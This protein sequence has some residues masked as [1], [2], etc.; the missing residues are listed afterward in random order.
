MGLASAVACGGSSDGAS[1]GPT[2][3]GS[4]GSSGTSGGE[5]SS[6][7][8][9]SSGESSS[10]S[11]GSSGDAS[12]DA[13]SDGA[14]VTTTTSSLLAAGG[15]LAC[16]I[17]PAG[18]L[19]CWGAS[20]TP[21]AVAAGSTFKDIS[22]GSYTYTYDFRGCAIRSDDTLWCFES[23][24]MSL[25]Q[26]DTGSFTQ[27][28]V[29][30]QNQCAIAK[31]GA[32]YCWGTN[33]TYGQL[34]VGDN[35][36]THTTLVQVGTD[37][38]WKRV[39]TSQDHTCALDATGALYCW[40]LD[41][42]GQ[43]G[44]GNPDATV[45]NYASSPIAIAAGTTWSDVSVHSSVTCGVR[46][47]GALLCWGQGAYLGVNSRTPATVDTAKDWAKVRLSPNHACAIKKTGTLY[48]WGF[49]SF[50]QIGQPADPNG[51]RTTPQQV[52]SDADWIDVAVGAGFSCATKSDATIRCWGTNDIGQLGQAVAGHT[53]PQRVGAA[54]E[55]SYVGAGGNG[56]CAVK[57]NGTL[58]CW[59]SGGGLSTPSQVPVQIGAGTTW[60]TAK[61]GGYR[62]CATQ[63]DGSLYCWTP[64]VGA[65]AP[66]PT[67]LTGV[68]SYS[69]GSDHQCA[70][71]AGSLYCWGDGIFGKL[72]NGSNDDE[73]SPTKVGAATWSHVAA[74]ADDT[75][76]V[77]SDGTTWCWGLGYSSPQ[78]ITTATTWTALAQN[79][80]GEN[81]LGLQGGTL[82]SWSWISSIESV[83]AVTDWTSISAGQSHSCG[84]RADGSLSCYGNNA[85]GQLGDGTTANRAAPV[86]VG[87]A[88]DWTMV[89][90][91]GAFTCGI[92]A[93]G[94][95]YCWGD[96]QFGQLGDGLAWSV[97]PL[98]VQ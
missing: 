65:P 57:K 45:A 91:G 62:A 51:Y 28:A 96:D 64:G 15:D 58:D 69:V 46:G 92:R 77:R 67:S 52:G 89:S 1:G 53:T 6:G 94:D 78:Q 79:P 44:D 2:D 35:A 84:I 4:S 97:T 60:A 86:E 40:G 54:G 73:A 47:D 63:T 88:K 81:Y 76:A 71:A 48:C 75:C 25:A 22:L 68:T 18:A 49:D 36:T 56:L 32:L 41:H 80:Q 29:G 55:W 93:G 31:T 66:S 72:G 98:V 37:T 59:C 12:T 34:G 16:A 23:S 85:H 17:S 27:T 39:V 10:G 19:K 26:V 42:A 21:H 90:A 83:G 38:N 8:S 7:S 87:V 9:G 95:L 3:D 11:S 14:V 5:G 82:Y 20:S 13:G 74:G 43:L 24:S 70:I 61:A 33:N 30:Y 50:G